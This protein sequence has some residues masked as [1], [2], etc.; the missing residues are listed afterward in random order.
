MRYEKN[1]DIILINNIFNTEC[2]QKVISE[3]SAKAF[4]GNMK[5]LDT[6][7]QEQPNYQIVVRTCCNNRFLTI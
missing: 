1:S 4:K 7:Y 2:L 6:S 3:P 5:A